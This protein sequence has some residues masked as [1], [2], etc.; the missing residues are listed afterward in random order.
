M[1]GSNELYQSI[2]REFYETTDQ[3]K[4]MKVCQDTYDWKA[5][6]EKD[7]ARRNQTCEICS[8]FISLSNNTLQCIYCNVV[9]HLSCCQEYYPKM[10]HTNKEHWVCYYCQDSLQYDKHYHERA[11]ATKEAYIKF[12]SSQIIISRN[13]R[14][15]HQYREYGRMYALIVKLQMRFRLKCRK[16]ELLI[17]M[18]K[19]LRTVKLRISGFKNVLLAERENDV[20]SN[21]IP[22]VLMKD[23]ERLKRKCFL[24]Y[25]VI[26]VYDNP[27]DETTNQTTCRQTWKID[28]KPISAEAFPNTCVDILL[29]E[30]LIFSSK[31]FCCGIN[32][33]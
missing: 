33:A 6:V 21:H 8:R 1:N 18:Q 19:K 28:S 9:F 23:E 27:N 4:L 2:L 14:M 5:P 32:E 17:S 11:T 29:D 30:K 13:W 20:C 25:Y 10:N 24:L 3:H 26:S 31:V 7:Y 12:N 22:V 15:Y 16:K